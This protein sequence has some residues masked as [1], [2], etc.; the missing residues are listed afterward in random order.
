MKIMSKIL[1]AFGAVALVCGVVGYIGIQGIGKMSDAAHEVNRVRVPSII[2]LHGIQTGI[3]AI[4]ADNCALCVESLPDERRKGIG[5]GIDAA[6]AELDKGWKLYEPLPQ[7]VEEAAK[8]KEFV[9]AFEEWK[10]IAT[11]MRSA[12]ERWQ[13]A[14]AAGEANAP[15][16]Y[17]TAMVKFDQI[18]APYRRA[19]DLLDQ[20]FKIND[21]IAAQQADLSD[22]AASA[23]TVTAMSVTAGGLVLAVGIGVFFSRNIV[24]AIRPVVSRAQMIT[25][26]DLT[27]S[28]LDARRRD[29]LGDIATAF[30][31]MSGS[32]RTLVQQIVG[33]AGQVASAA[34]EI[35]ASAE[36]MAQGMDQQEKQ[37]GQVSAAVEEMSASATEVARKS[38]DA[39]SAAQESGKQAQEGGSVVDQTVTEMKGIASQVGESVQAVGALGA[40][41][42]QIGQ[43][44]GVINDIADQ[45]NLLALNAA[46]EA[47]RAGEHG[48]GFA[49]VADEV[50]KLA[51]RT[52]QATKQ[53]ADSIKEIQTETGVAVQKI[54]CSTKQVQSGVQLAGAA[55]Q[56]LQKIVT[57]SNGLGDMVRVIAA[58]AQQ[59]SATA[60][61]I[62]RNIEQI[63][64]V[65]KESSE[66]ARQA[67]QA[68]T[69]LG[70]QAESLSALVGKFKV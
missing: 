65:T 24:G 1:S 6:W 33:S 69:Q 9:P 42:E 46:I 11:D 10:K 30:N 14:R 39:A 38:A 25:A 15:E 56:A 51:E 63:S 23:T 49:V 27:G 61:D 32:L 37:T 20:I 34:T 29:E 55:G 45:T 12:L 18:Q 3:I 4:R 17:K 22:R 59:Q 21:V 41:S 68:A 52:T 16:L 43:I 13:T 2:G 28:D 31:T 19:V 66:G 48:R 47:A 54:E 7:T 58:A 62:A 40:K 36:E 5:A 8:W 35:A 50:R 26:G 70:Q 64:A 44:I 60:T 53:V 57:S 67:A